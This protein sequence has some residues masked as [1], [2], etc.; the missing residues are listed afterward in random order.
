MPSYRKKYA[1]KP[2][3]STYSKYKAKKTLKLYNKAKTNDAIVNTGGTTL[4]NPAVKDK[5]ITMVYTIENAKLF[6]YVVS[7]YANTYGAFQFKL[8][9]LGSSVQ[10]AVSTVFRY[11]RIKNVK[12]RWY[13]ISDNANGSGAQDPSILHR[14]CYDI[15]QVNAPY[16]TSAL[17]KQQENVM[18]HEF[19]S[20]TATTEYNIRP[21]QLV[22]VATPGTPYGQDTGYTIKPKW[23][24]TTD[25]TDAHYGYQWCFE[26][27]PSGQTMKIQCD[28]EYTIEYKGQRGIA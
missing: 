14:Y 18:R 21:R 12:I 27:I 15:N 1:R 3:K 10:S 13:I 20:N 8:S 26:N 4:L 23:I 7:A 11:Y 22:I 28:L 2:R 9:D 19:N 5:T 24:S 25:G 16:S 17:F 6:Q